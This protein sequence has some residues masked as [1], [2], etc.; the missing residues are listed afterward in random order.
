MSKYFW[1]NPFYDGRE[2]PILRDVFANWMDG[3]GIFSAM[4]NL[5]NVT[6]PW[7]SDATA[8]NL[9][10]D[11]AYFGNHSGSKYCSPIIKHLVSDDGK[12][13]SDAI[14]TIAK[15]IVAKYLKNWERLWITN[16]VAYSAINNYNLTITRELTSENSNDRVIEGRDAHTGANTISE[17]G[18]RELDSENSNERVTDAEESHTGTETDAVTGDE[19]TTHGKTETQ[20]SY[21][22]GYNSEATDREPSELVQTEQGGTTE[23]ENSTNSTTTR[24]LVDSTDSTVTDAGSNHEEEDTTRTETD[25][26]NLVDTTNRTIG[27]EG[28]NHEVEEITRTG[29]IGDST[30]QKILEEERELWMWNYFKTI[31]R[32]IDEELTLYV[33]DPC[34]A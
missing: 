1:L 27:D 4:G 5:E 17:T 29:K 7:A 33:Y 6:L 32:N 31:F 25:T 16:T 21:Q 24:N 23:V 30:T 10:L 20:T 9:L 22:F 19:T 11:I 26:R 18:R 8:T 3:G 28:A 13:S 34:R 15:I 12:L 2:E 14:S